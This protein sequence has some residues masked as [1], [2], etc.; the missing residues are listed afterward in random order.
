[1]AVDCVCCESLDVTALELFYLT[2]NKFLLSKVTLTLEKVY[3][4]SNLQALNSYTNQVRAPPI[5]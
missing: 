5:I 1:M 4:A 2:S 3:Y